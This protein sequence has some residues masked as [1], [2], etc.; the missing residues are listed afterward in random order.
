MVDKNTKVVL[1]E[2]EK[3]IL[4][5]MG[6]EAMRAEIAD[7][8]VAAFKLM[9]IANFLNGRECKYLKERD[10]ARKQVQKL[11]QDLNE[12]Q[13]SY[14]AYQEK[15]ALQI[16]LT[17]T[18][19]HKEEEVEKLTLVTKMQR[20][21]IAELED[22]LKTSASSSVADEEESSVD[23]LGEFAGFSRAAMIA[24]IME[25]EST[26]VEIA[27]WSFDNAVAQIKCLNPAVKL[28][29]EGLSELKE[30]HDGVLVSLPPE[31]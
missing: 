25:C 16:S 30:V 6:P 17:T 29:T 3:I 31:E 11:G 23:P 26:A 9:A 14:E 2:A 1:S 22:Q 20:A 24:R 13:A 21:K 8:T 27:K 10:D 4:S 15:S 5:D 7:A 18:L 28:V 12:L 19:A